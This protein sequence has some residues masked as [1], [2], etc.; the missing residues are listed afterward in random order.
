MNIGVSFASDLHVIIMIFSNCHSSTSTIHWKLSN[1]E[2][3]KR[4][5]VKMIP[6]INFDPHRE[7]SYQRDNLG[8]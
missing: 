6:N 4:M 8:K 3:F 5:K 1:Q 7:A 2:N